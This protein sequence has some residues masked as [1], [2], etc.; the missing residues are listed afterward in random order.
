MAVSKIGIVYLSYH[1]DPYLEDAVASWSRLTYDR[2]RVE[3]FI[4]DNPHPVHGTSMRAIEELVL[5]RSGVDIPFVRVLPQKE[6]RGYAGGNN[7]GIREAL[8]SG[9]EYI[10]LHNDDGYMAPDS[11][12]LLVDAMEKDRTIAAAQPLILLSPDTE[13]VNSSGNIFHYLGFGFCGDYR[14]RY[15]NLTLRDVR[16]VAYVSGSA[17]LLRAA[18]LER[19]GLLDEDFFMYHEDL[20][21]SFRFRMAGFRVV[22][23]RN[24][25]FYH[26]YQFGRSIQKFYWMERNRFAVLLLFFRLPTLLLLLPM[27]LL[28][29][30]GQWLFALKRGWGRE[31]ANLYAYWLNPKQWPLWFQKRHA[32]QRTRT[33]RDRDLL[34]TASPTIRFQE[35]E[36]EHWM[37]T[38]VGNPLMKLYY[39]LVIRTC[40]WW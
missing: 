21:L 4:V 10:F 15:C 3:I 12:S 23:L 9:C 17:L 37:L 29:E 25:L 13:F 34:A 26:K 36:M 16:D 24:S 27:L 14:A 35:K 31:R 7:V 20:E 8:A 11:L 18:A 1:S 5:P 39:L 22:A 19:V 2:D 6:N 30:C 32:I 40:I 38:Y 33:I 28:M